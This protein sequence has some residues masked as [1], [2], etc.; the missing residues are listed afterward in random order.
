MRGLISK[1][2][3]NGGLNHGKKLHRARK[4]EMESVSGF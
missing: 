4:V 2:S 1:S 3:E